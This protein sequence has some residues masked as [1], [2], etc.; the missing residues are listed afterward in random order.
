M[1]TL[2]SALER[3][4]QIAL[5]SPRELPIHLQREELSQEVIDRLHLQY[6]RTK[7]AKIR[8]LLYAIHIG[9]VY[10]ISKKFSIPGFTE[11]DFLQEGSIGLL[12]AITRYDPRRKV[13]FSTF[14][15]HTI[16]GNIR[17]AIR[18]RGSMLHYPRGFYDSIPKMIR[19]RD[20]LTHKLQRSPT[21]QEIAIETGLPEQEIIDCIQ[22]YEMRNPCSLDG[23][24]QGEE[25]GS[26][27]MD[28]E[29]D[30]RATAEFEL[31][32]SRLSK[33]VIWDYL[34]ELPDPRIKRIL[35]YKH[36]HGIALKDTARA[37]GLSV[38]RILQLEKKA[39]AIL[40][41]RLASLD[42]S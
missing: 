2:E 9:L 11:E 38:T 31:A 37:I 14:A 12:D 15:T 3:R 30:E 1:T 35:I 5:E 27:Y 17:R 10:P 28:A 29:S 16:R 24:K 7:D 33:G 36:V 19:A 25:N 40:R 22:I 13:E 34:D 23:G 42:I 32:E 8:E 4:L 39:V 21:T 41:R 6:W 20:I 18:D 26:S